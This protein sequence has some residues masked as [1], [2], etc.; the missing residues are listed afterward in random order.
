MHGIDRWL[1]R[2]GFEAHRHRAVNLK[3][4]LCILWLCM[5][6]PG[7]SLEA[8]RHPTPAANDSCIERL[9]TE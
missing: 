9:C 7:G 5:E 8:H 3:L 4:E 1:R 6:W 2:R